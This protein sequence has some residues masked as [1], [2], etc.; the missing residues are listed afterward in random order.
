[1]SQ[2][3]PIPPTASGNYRILRSVPTYD[4]AQEIVDT[5]SDAGFPV[6]HVRVVGTGLRSVE[7]V[8]GR[9]TNGKAAL[10]GMVSGAWLGLFVGLLLG[11]FAV[12][13]WL[14][15]VLWGVALGAVWGLVLGLVGHA[16]T[17]GRRDFRSIQGFEADA[18]DVLVDA[19][20]VDDAAA[21]LAGERPTA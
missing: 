9:M 8:T 1:M 17:G 10:Y 13:A 14:S 3:S 5:L 2:P 7:Q 19:E 11:L 12:G 4:A 20:H 6:E 18:Y 15:V 16:A 21:H